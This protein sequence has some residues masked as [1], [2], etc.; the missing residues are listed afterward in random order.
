MTFRRSGAHL[1]ARPGGA[2]SLESPEVGVPQHSERSEFMENFTWN[3]KE[4]LGKRRGTNL[5]RV[6]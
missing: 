3:L 5:V 4:C 1:G 2:L 6:C